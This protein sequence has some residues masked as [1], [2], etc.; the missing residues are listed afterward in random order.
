MIATVTVVVSARVSQSAGS[1]RIRAPPLPL[2]LMAMLPSIRNARPPNIFVS[3]SP[4]PVPI[5]N[6]IRSASSVS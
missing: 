4:G 6:R 3:V 1:T 2:A 5:R